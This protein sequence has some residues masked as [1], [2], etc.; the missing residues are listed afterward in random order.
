MSI[1]IKQSQLASTPLIF[2]N[3]LQVFIGSLYVNDFDYLDRS[4]RT[5]LQA[6]AQFRSNP[7][8]IDQLYVRSQT[9]SMVPIS[10]FVTKKSTDIAADYCS[11][12]Y[13]Q[14]NRN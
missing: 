3:T 10:N 5:Y 14:V 8:D 4:Y 12:Q 9:G 11:L 13:V 2:F 6:D 1:V 7:K